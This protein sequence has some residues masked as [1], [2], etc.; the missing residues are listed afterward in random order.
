M[1]LLP[2]HSSLCEDCKCDYFLIVDTEGFRAPEVAEQ[3]HKH[4]NELAT[5]V[6]GV[7]NLTIINLS[8][9]TAGDMDDVLQT[10]VRAFLQM[11]EVRLTPS[12]HFVH[13]NVTAVQ[14]GEKTMHGHLKFMKTLNMKTQAAAKEEGLEDKTYF[15][16]VINFNS[17]KHIFHFKNLWKVTHQWL[18]LIQGI[19]LMLSF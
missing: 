4:D 7:A 16:D 18:Q 12:C 1:Q 9:E 10:T 6:I 8:G 13:Q 2:I 15:A 17:E 11:K 19:V 14:A 5:F 3:T